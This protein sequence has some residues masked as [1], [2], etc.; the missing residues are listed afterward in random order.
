M[1]IDLRTKI[2]NYGRNNVYMIYECIQRNNLYMICECIQFYIKSKSMY[3]TQPFD[4]ECKVIM[5]HTW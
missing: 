1:S 4:E 5:L 3:I 2:K